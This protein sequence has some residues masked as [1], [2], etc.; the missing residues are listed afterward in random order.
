MH[1]PSF[2]LRQ[3]LGLIAAITLLSAII[4]PWLARRSYPAERQACQANLKQIAVACAQYL[5][6]S[7]GT[8]P[9]TQFLAGGPVV[10]RRKATY[11][12]ADALIPYFHNTVPYQ[13]SAQGTDGSAKQP[14]Q[15]GYTDYYLNAN[16]GGIRDSSL[17][18]PSSTVL[19]GEGND[20][21]DTADARYSYSMVPSKWLNAPGS[22]ANRHR[23]GMNV[24]F[25]DG[26]VKWYGMLHRPSDLI[27]KDLNQDFHAGIVMTASK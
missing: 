16:L 26:H 5:S 15:S 9:R 12:W 19:L 2:T 20:G 13:C 23:D 27:V 6:D 14:W 25:V 18:V 3:S 4:F 1:R 22:P 10:T 24:A 7:R 11:G 8:Y 17:H 21:R